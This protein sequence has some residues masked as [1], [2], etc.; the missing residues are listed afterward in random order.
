MGRTVECGALPQPTDPGE[1]FYNKGQKDHDP[2]S[3]LAM[4]RIETWF[5]AAEAEER[6]RAPKAQAG[7]MKAKTDEQALKITMADDTYYRVSG[8]GTECPPLDIISSADS[9][10]KTVKNKAA[11]WGLKYDEKTSGKPQNGSYTGRPA[12]C[13]VSS[14]DGT[15]L[16]N[17]NPA[18]KMHAD[19][20]EWDTHVCVKSEDIA[21]DEMELK[22]VKCPKDD[23]PSDICRHKSTE[24]GPWNGPCEVGYAPMAKKAGSAGFL[25][26]S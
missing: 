4:T 20:P 18:G 2:A 9:C 7:M 19:F 22:C 13:S 1:N 17:S 6:A 15:M 5:K 8:A 11:L 12:G 16:F 10:F 24:T 14:K 23:S 26:L 21:K 25:Q 3:V